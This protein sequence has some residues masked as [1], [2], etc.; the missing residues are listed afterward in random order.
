MQL[1]KHIKETRLLPSAMDLIRI[2]KEVVE[3]KYVAT[4]C[5]EKPLDSQTI[6]N[7]REKYREIR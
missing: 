1:K 3:I 6:Q 5:K 2:H 4:H 7:S